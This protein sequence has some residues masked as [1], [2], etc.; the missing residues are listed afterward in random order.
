M[1]GAAVLTGTLHIP[2]CADGEWLKQL[3][4]E[5]LITFKGKHGFPVFFQ[6]WGV[7]KT[8]QPCKL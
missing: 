4:A 1:A 7:I 5:Q 6:I 8:A 3:T 2:T